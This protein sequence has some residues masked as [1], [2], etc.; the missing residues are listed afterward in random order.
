MNKGQLTC[1]I[2]IKI[3]QYKHYAYALVE[4]IT[5]LSKG[6]FLRLVPATSRGEKSYYVN[7]PFLLQNLVAGT[8]FGS[9]DLSHQIKPVSVFGTSPCDLFLKTLRVNC[10]LDKPLRPVPQC[11]LF[12]GLVAGTIR[13]EKSPRVCDLKRTLVSLRHF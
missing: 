12:R 4:D 6:R 5:V 13:R 3:Y 7:W 2:G 8:N 1:T 11:K 9:C 10:S